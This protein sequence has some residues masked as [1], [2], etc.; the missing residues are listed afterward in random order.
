MKEIEATT[1]PNK[2]QR[3]TFAEVLSKIT[4]SNPGKLT[5]RPGITISNQILFFTI[6]Y[7]YNNRKINE[8]ITDINDMPFGEEEKLIFLTKLYKTAIDRKEIIKAIMPTNI[9]ITIPVRGGKKEIEEMKSINNK[10]KITP[11]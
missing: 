1:E 5:I 4:K 10:N 11:Y 7:K 3:N 2:K 8:V 6:Q 9:K